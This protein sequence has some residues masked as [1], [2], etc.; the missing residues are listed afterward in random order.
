MDNL[1]VILSPD[2]FDADDVLVSG[3]RGETT[4]SDRQDAVETLKSECETKQ[5]DSLIINSTRRGDEA[6]LEELGF[7]IV[8]Q[9]GEN[10][11]TTAVYHL[12]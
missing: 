6:F 7:D 10:G 8:E 12:E 4:K 11:L 3:F 5:K 1:P 2:G 9:Y